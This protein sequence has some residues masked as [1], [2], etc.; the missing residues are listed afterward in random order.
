MNRYVL[1]LY[2]TGQTPRA[3]RAVA[4]LRQICEQE[5]GQNFELLIVDVL[6]DP[7]QAEDQRILAT[8]TLV[9]EQPL[10]RRCIIGDL[11]DGQK[12]LMLLGI[13]FYKNAGGDKPLG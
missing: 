5:L 8:P 6:Q 2:I 9:R 11:S 3:E 1:K 12:V 7:Q 4:N 13:T 10:P